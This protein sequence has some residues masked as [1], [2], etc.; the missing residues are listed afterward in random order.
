MVVVA[1]AIRDPFLSVEIV[2]DCLCA[3]RTCWGRK[4]SLLFF[5]VSSLSFPPWE[6]L[7]SKFNRGSITRARAKAREKPTYPPGLKPQRLAAGSFGS[8]RLWQET[9]WQPSTLLGLL[10][11]AHCSPRLARLCQ[12]ASESSYRSQIFTR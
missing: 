4:T 1:F 9:G 2:L 12:Q 3:Y 5:V 8:P 7:Y 11:L 6:K 10:I